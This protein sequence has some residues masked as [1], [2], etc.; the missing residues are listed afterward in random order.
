MVAKEFDEFVK[1]QHGSAVE[2][3]QVDWERQR[4]EWLAYLDSLY[5]DIEGFLNQ[6]TSSGQIDIK[7]KFIDLNEEDIGSYRARQM[8]LRI[9]R[10]EVDLVPAGTRFIG[11]KGYV[12]VIGSA[13]KSSLVLAN[14]DRVSAL[15][16]VRIDIPL[17]GPITRQNIK[18]RNK[19][20]SDSE[21]V[22]YSGKIE[23]VWRILPSPPDR[24]LFEL[25]HESF[26]Q[27]IMEV[28][29]G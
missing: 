21:L 18:T 7:Y 16:E 25:T 2:E 5:R 12:E 15:P 14:K 29:N 3:A 24:R 10:Q 1:R 19:N 27:L 26:F 6:Y 22:A 17:V 4:D 9:G 8:V 28:S 13:G 20:R 11:F 23:W